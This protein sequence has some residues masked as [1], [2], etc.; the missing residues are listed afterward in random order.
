MSKLLLQHAR[1]ILIEFFS[2]KIVYTIPK[3]IPDEVKLPKEV[4]VK[5]YPD[6][7]EI[8]FTKKK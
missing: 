4:E 7:V 8:T 5:D 1:N 3:Y 6:R 2:D